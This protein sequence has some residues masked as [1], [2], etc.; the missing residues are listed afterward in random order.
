MI[1]MKKR[2]LRTNRPVSPSAI[3]MSLVQQRRNAAMSEKDPTRPQNFSELMPR[4]PEQ[5]KNIVV[6]YLRSLGEGGV[7]VPDA[8]FKEANFGMVRISKEKLNGAPFDMVVV[9]KVL[10]PSMDGGEYRGEIIEVLGDIGN[11]DVRMLAVLRQFGLSQTFPQQ[12]RDEVDPL[13]FNPEQADIEAEIARGRRDLRDMFTITIDGEDAK[14]LDDAIS[15]EPLEDGKMR[16]LVHIADVTHYVREGT[17]LDEEAKLRATSVYLVDRVIPMLPPKLSNGL[18]SLNPN[19]DRLSMTAD[20]IIDAD[21]ETIDGEIYE[22]VIRSNHRT[23]YNECYRLLFEPRKEDADKIELIDALWLMKGLTDRLDDR[24]KR[25]GAL[26]FDFPETKIELDT[27]GNPVKIMP[28]PINYCHGMIEQ[29]MICAN[30]FV[31]KKFALMNYPFVY[32]VHEEPDKMKIT[33]FCTVARSYGAMGA[34][35]GKITPLAIKTYMSTVTNEEVKPALDTLLLRSMAK[36]RYAPVNMG[37]FGLASEYYCHFTSPIRRYPDTQIHR[38]IKSYLA[39]G[40]EERKHFAAIVDGVSAH[41]SDME[42]NSVEAERQSNQVKI[43]MYMQDKIG[44]KYTGRISG[45]I[46]AGIFVELENTVEGFVAYRTMSDHFFF[47]ERNMRA[48]G[49]RG[50]VLMI[51]QKVNVE[52]ASV[53][54]D[55]NRVDFIIDESNSDNSSN[56]N[57]H[58]KI[59]RR[60]AKKQAK[61]A[62][63]EEIN[64]RRG[65]DSKVRKLSYS[66]NGSRRG[67]GKRGR[68]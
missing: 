26:E 59:G 22:S 41:S 39:N 61:V 14:D 56:P 49:R 36:A 31:A 58:A 19:V 9:A 25:L 1:N 54:T 47:D 44:E 42:R 43:A 40:P 53:D 60:K 29:F 68:R 51:G 21:G 3:N 50:N 15:I 45:I 48:V 17:A 27:E 55:L 12:V 10:N 8:S 18:C 62:M 16:L 46:S 7:V 20:M 66:S 57:G 64:A 6:G 5:A 37:H 23:S 38:I 33:R 65:R 67:G 30:E 4:G 13:P 63:R 52:V 32:R 28:Y 11:N 34:I 2:H 24:R 35:R